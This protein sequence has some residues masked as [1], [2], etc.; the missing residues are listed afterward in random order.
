LVIVSRFI[1][2]FNVNVELYASEETFNYDLPTNIDRMWLGILLSL[3][4]KN[5]WKPIHRE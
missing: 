4:E 3:S 1:R 2:S 5:V